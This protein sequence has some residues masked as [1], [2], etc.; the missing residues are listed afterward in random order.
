M[1]TS[2]FYP[3]LL[4]ASLVLAQSTDDVVW[5]SPSKGSV[6]HSGDLLT[7]TWA[8][9]VSGHGR[10]S[11]SFQLCSQPDNCGSAVW[12]AVRSSDDGLQEASFYMPNVTSGATFHLRMEDDYGAV[13]S[14]PE[15]ILNPPTESLQTV[16]AVDPSLAA[17]LHGIAQMPLSEFTSADSASMPEVPLSASAPSDSG[18]GAWMP[19]PVLASSV[20]DT[21]SQEPESV[22]LSQHSRVDS[23]ASSLPG[24]PVDN[25]ATFPNPQ[26]DDSRNHLER[27]PASSVKLPPGT[28][29]SPTVVNAS[30][31]PMSQVHLPLSSNTTPTPLAPHSQLAAA[32][33]TTSFPVAAIAAPLSLAAVIGI[34]AFAAVVYNRRKISRDEAQIAAAACAINGN[35]K[36]MEARNTS[37]FSRSSAYSS[38]PSTPTDCADAE[39]TTVLGRLTARWAPSLPHTDG[40]QDIAHRQDGQV[41]GLAG[42]PSQKFDEIPLSPAMPPPLHVRNMSSG[43]MSRFTT[44]SVQTTSPV[45]ISPTASKRAG[46]YDAVSKAFGGHH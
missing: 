21:D 26:P 2:H 37:F 30:A 40:H 39:K 15:F 6:Y 23:T 7:A 8:P 35:M 11:P 4:A 5:S 24:V 43:E 45:E 46:L 44:S 19:I 12:P 42:L 29:D 33:H 18:S 13:S 32:S 10:G 38:G 27:Q 1:F 28:S 9:S 3:L 14:S 41:D 16:P 20:S 25:V 36:L 17:P 22:P 34:V 31:P